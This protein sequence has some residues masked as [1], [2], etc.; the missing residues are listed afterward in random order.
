[1]FKI[2]KLESKIRNKFNSKHLVKRSPVSVS[3]GLHFLARSFFPLWDYK[4]AHEYECGYEKRPAEQYYFFCEKVK[5]ISAL[6][7]D[8]RVC[9]GSGKSILKLL[10]EYNYAKYT[11]G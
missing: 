3:K 9:K 11:K 5:H 7:K 2:S 6:I 8:Y 1:V 10:D 4:I